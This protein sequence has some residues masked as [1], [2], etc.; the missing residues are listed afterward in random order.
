MGG[1]EFDSGGSNGKNKKGKGCINLTD[2][3]VKIK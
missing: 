1:G 2:N 3:K